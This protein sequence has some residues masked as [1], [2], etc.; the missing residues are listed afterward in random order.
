MHM[1]RQRCVAARL[2][3]P[4]PISMRKYGHISLACA[5]MES[6]V[7]KRTRTGAGGCT[8]FRPFALTGSDSFSDCLD[9]AWGL[10]TLFYKIS[11]RCSCP[12]FSL[13]CFAKDGNAW[14]RVAECQVVQRKPPH[15]LIAVR[16][17]TFFLPGRPELRQD[18]TAPSIPVTNPANTAFQKL[19]FKTV[20][21]S[22]YL[23]FSEDAMRLRTA[24]CKA[25]PS[26]R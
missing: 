16:S 11:R 14:G 17:R 22:T 8:I 13:Q 3:I 23:S 10:L 1:A 15:G 18:R 5:L 4:K 2:L 19:A 6:A 12:L 7:H 24:T 20:R 9:C 21:R 26:R 25:G